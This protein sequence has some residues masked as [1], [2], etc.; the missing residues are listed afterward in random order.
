MAASTDKSAVAA[1]MAAL[2]IGSNVGG[3]PVLEAYSSV[4]VAATA[5]KPASAVLKDAKDELKSLLG[6]T[7][8]DAKVVG[9][10]IQPQR[11]SAPAAAAPAPAPAVKKVVKAAPAPPKPAPAPKPVPKYAPAKPVVKPAAPKS[12]A[13]AEK[14]AEK[15]AKA[16]KE[17]AALDAAAKKAAE[18]AAK[19]Q[20]D[21]QKLKV[22]VIECTSKSR[23]SYISGTDCSA[24]HNAM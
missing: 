16:A 8:Y 21:L 11:S 9:K 5:E 23:Y 2:V 22:K 6:D 10:E 19:K 1:A 3:L 20:A 12:N 13:A 24:K 17:K 14:T 18:E 7:K 4:A 15:T